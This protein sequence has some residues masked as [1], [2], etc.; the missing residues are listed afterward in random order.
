MRA[1]LRSVD[2]VMGHP[3]WRVRVAGLAFLQAAA[4]HNMFLLLSQTDAAQTVRR[5][6]PPPPSPP[7]EGGE[8]GLWWGGGGSETGA[9]LRQSV[10]RCKC[11]PVINV[12]NRMWIQNLFYHS[13]AIG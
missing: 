2:A 4:F 11:S 3:Y 12:S 10:T 13:L 5:A 1:L 8:D 6:P 7:R 9:T